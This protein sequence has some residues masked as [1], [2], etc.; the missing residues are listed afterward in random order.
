[1]PVFADVDPSTLNL[2]PGAV[3]AAITERTRA[4]ASRS[5]CSAIRASSTSCARSRPAHGLPLIVDF[6]A[7]RS[8]PSTRA[9]SIGAPRPSAVR[10]RFYPNKQITTGEGGVVTTHSRGARQLLITCGTRGALVL[11]ALVPPRAARFQLPHHG[12]QAALGIGQLER[13]RRGC[14]SCA[15]RRCGGTPRRYSAAWTASGQPLERQRDHRRSWFR[16]RGRSSRGRRSRRGRFSR[17]LSAQGIEAG[18]YV[19]RGHFSRHIA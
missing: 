11:L 10:S 18:L 19:P 8:A 5:T 9:S 12:H 3:E 15:R 1:M 16:L 2:D 17:G 14:S 7:R 13:P 4:D 6:I